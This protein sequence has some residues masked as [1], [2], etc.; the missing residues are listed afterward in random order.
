MPRADQLA[1]VASPI[2]EMGCFSRVETNGGGFEQIQLLSGQNPNQAVRSWCQPFND[3]G[4]Q[5]QMLERGLN[6]IR[7]NPVP[8]DVRQLMFRVKKR[9]GTDIARSFDGLNDARNI[10]DSLTYAKE[11]G[12][13]AQAALSVTHSPL[14]TVDYYHA[15]AAELID[16]G[17]DEIAIK[18]MAGIGRPASTGELV[19]RIKSDYPNVLVQYHGH[20][21]PGFSVATTLEVARAGAD[22]IDVSMEPLSWG[23]AHADLLT[24]HAMLI[25]AGFSLP[26]INMDAYMRVRSLTQSFIDEW[27]GYYINPRNRF[28]NSLLIGPGL[29]G[30]MMG[31]LMADLENNLSNLNKWLRKQQ[32]PELTQDDL[33]IRL[34]R[35]VEDIWPMMGYPPLVTPYSQYVKNVALMNVIQMAK[36][37]ERWS[38]VDDNTWDMLL[39]KSGRVPG[40]IH[41][42]LIALANEQG[43][44][45]YEGH[46][47]DLYPDAL[48][49]FRT[50]MREKGWDPGQDEEELM[51]LAMHPQQYRRYRSGEAKKDFEADLAAR[52]ADAAPSHVPQAIAP[53][54]RPAQPK[55]LQISVNGT[56][57]TVDIAYPNEPAAEQTTV[58]NSQPAVATAVQAPGSPPGNL[59][60]ISSPLEGTFYWTKEASDTPKQPGDLIKRGEPIGYVEA[61]KVFNAIVADRDGTLVDRRPNGSSV[62]EDDILATLKPGT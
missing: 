59:H 30:G 15:L 48:E 37:R 7:M 42:D 57:Y 35:E 5:T 4:I 41:P 1:H 56:P 3:A 38:I 55:R 11:G 8:K 53:A 25:D 58:T 16:H 13:I 31:S 19:R 20:S 17:A 10:K 9:Q 52:K 23:T 22:I 21:G 45:F 46:P 12:M 18:D 28:M 36:G 6:G 2:I 44:E 62:E 47:Q 49:E 60:E 50:E 43:R 40:D 14:H 27:L 39:G 51:E 26:A 54:N 61:M 29:P 32:Q 34:F 24:V 33:L